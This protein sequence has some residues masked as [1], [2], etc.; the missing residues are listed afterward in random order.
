M[1]E[2][3]DLT[4]QLKELAERVDLLESVRELNALRN[5]LPRLINDNEWERV[6]EL[7]STDAYLDYGDLGRADGRTAISEYFAGL[8]A[9]IEKDAM[10]SGVLVKQFVHGH[11]VEISGSRAT[12]VCDFEE[13][14]VFKEQ[15]FMV[16]GKFLD[17]YIRVDRRWLFARIE[18]NPFWVIPHGKGY[19]Q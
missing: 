3:S 18:L 4:A 13:R 19:A 6:G 2:E 8:P 12:G 1:H 14:V 16:A 7:F 5:R 9:R 17:E 15:S 11:E 10:T